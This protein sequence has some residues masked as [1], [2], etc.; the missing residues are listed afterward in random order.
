MSVVFGPRGWKASELIDLLNA[1]EYR[2]FG[3][4]EDIAK[5]IKTRTADGTDVLH[6]WSWDSV[7]SVHKDD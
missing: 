5:E 3:N 7:L 4:W 1:V 2:G 6:F